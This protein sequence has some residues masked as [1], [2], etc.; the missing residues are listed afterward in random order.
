MRVAA[1]PSTHAPRPRPQWLAVH[2]SFP[3]L[4]ATN[5]VPA[6][7]PRGAQ[8]SRGPAA[9]T[10]GARAHSRRVSCQCRPSAHCAPSA[11]SARRRG[12]HP[13][14]CDIRDRD[15]D[16]NQAAVL[17]DGLA[18]GRGLL[19][20]RR[21]L[22]RRRGGFGLSRC[23]CRLL[24][25]C[26]RVGAGGADTACRRPPLLR[27][28]ARRRVGCRPLGARRP[29]QLRSYPRV[30]QGYHLAAAKGMP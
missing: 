8:P 12:A 26:G 14:E 9:R 3:N 7:G 2:Q 28:T 23:C 18:K 17:E 27:H 21:Q 10:A 4:M 30:A 6:R 16:S 29:L 11:H 1:P 15:G 5:C 25:L 22:L 24:L 13:E 19:L 20:R